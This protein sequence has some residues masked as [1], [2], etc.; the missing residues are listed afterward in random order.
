MSLSITVPKCLRP[1]ILDSDVSEFYFGVV[2]GK[3]DPFTSGK[4]FST[5][6]A[7]ALAYAIWEIGHECFSECHFQD[8]AISALT[9]TLESGNARE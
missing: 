8:L 5:D 4:T 3:Y 1:F 7:K 2:L 9:E 6:K